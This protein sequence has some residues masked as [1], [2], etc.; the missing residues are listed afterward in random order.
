MRHTI[1]ET[2]GEEADIDDFD[3]EWCYLKSYLGR[4]VAA[5]R[6]F[7][8]YANVELGYLFIQHCQCQTELLYK[9]LCLYRVA[10]QMKHCDTKA[11]WVFGVFMGLGLIFHY[12]DMCIWRLFT[13]KLVTLYLS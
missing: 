7:M 12:A 11:G 1:Y 4:L 3:Y 5:T 9:N 6:S 10:I 8:K 13:T 2:A